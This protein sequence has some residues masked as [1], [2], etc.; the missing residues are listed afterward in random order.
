MISH[1]GD[2]AGASPERHRGVKGL[3]ASGRF[4]IWFIRHPL[5]KAFRVLH[6]AWF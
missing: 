2:S 1:L 5:P 6:C 3:R 4:R